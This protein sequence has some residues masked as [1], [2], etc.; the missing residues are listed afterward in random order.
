MQTL[1]KYTLH[2]ELGRGAYAVVWRAEDSRLGRTVALKVLKP[3]WL[4]DEM[5]QARFERE[6]STAADLYHPHIAVVHEVGEAEGRPYIA[7]RYVAGQPLDQMLKERGALPWAEALVIVEQVASALDYAHGRGLVHRDVKPAN[8]VVSVTEGAVL[9]D[10]GLARAIDLAQSVGL[11]GSAGQ[12]GTPYYRPPEL[13][14]GERKAG[15][16]TA[17]TDVYSLACVLVELVTGEV[18]FEGDTA[19]E[20]MTAHL[21]EVPALP[22]TW[23]AGVPGDMEAVVRQALAKKM[24]DRTASAGEFVGALGERDTTAKVDGVHTEVLEVQP[25]SPT[26]SG[27]VVATPENLA[28]L[29]ALAEPPGRIW[30]ERAE[31]ELCLVPAGE[32]LI[33]SPEGEGYD[34]EYPQHTV[35]LDSFYI[36][37]SPVTQAQY[38]RFVR[39]A[40]HR[41]PFRDG[42]WAEPY[43]WDQE[44]KTFP[45]GKADHPVVLVSWHDAVD[46]CQWAGLRLPTEAEWGMAA[47]G[48][49]GREYPWGSIWEAGHCNTGEAGIKGTTPVDQYPR[50]VSP[51][52][53]LD[54]AGNVW[55]WCQDRYVEGRDA[56]VVRGG[57]WDSL[58]F[59]A[60]SAYRPGSS[61]DNTSN[62]NG[63]RCGVSSTSSP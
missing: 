35:H 36:G 10:F 47:R 40:D 58:Q 51:Y 20:V 12:V 39:Q 52:G 59:G 31:M 18:L 44:R 56:K 16:P 33:G 41:V 63:F 5:A 49:D 21:M 14:L 9:T 55:E 27:L 60:R 53:M 8:I 15:P 3:G 62:D 43:N 32:F 23:P 29:L 42:D 2:Q 7:M 61:P 54:M 30:W 48:T 17:A 13:W 11:T 26:D 25:L 4:E 37:R 34:D 50:G 57:S 22:A 45:Q 24:A 1:G 6:A 28:E 38:G 19:A 46:Y